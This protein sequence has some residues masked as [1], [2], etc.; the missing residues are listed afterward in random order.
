MISVNTFRS[1]CVV[2]EARP[3]SAVATFAAISS[4][5][6]ALTPVS[7]R[8][9]AVSQRLGGSTGFEDGVSPGLPRGLVVVGLLAG[10]AVAGLRELFEPLERLVGVG[11]AA[12]H[13]AQP[14][15]GTQFPLEPAEGGGG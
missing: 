15:A 7:L 14:A 10:S 1:Y 5:V 9:P 3:A 8:P 12:M 4:N 6:S 2:A 13:R 11:A